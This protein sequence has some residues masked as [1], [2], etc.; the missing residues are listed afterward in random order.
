LL[1]TLIGLR[2]QHFVDSFPRG[3]NH[4]FHHITPCFYHRL[5]FNEG[6]LGSRQ[7]GENVQGC[8]PFCQALEKGIAGLLGQMRKF[9]R[10]PTFSEKSHKGTPGA[11][12]QMGV[13][14]IVHKREL[15]YS[16][17]PSRTLPAATP[18]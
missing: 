8:R 14:H 5:E 6:G 13:L 7:Q 1:E 18:S 16:R 3:E 2:T 4:I 12:F 15:Q 17:S 10:T 9:G 11:P